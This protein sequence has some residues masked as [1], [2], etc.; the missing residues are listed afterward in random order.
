MGGLWTAFIGWFLNGAAESTRQEELQRELLHGVPVSTLMDPTPVVAT[1]GL[2]VQDFVFEDVLQRGHRALL[3]ADSGHL[4]GIVTLGDAKKLAQEDWPTTPVSKIMTGV[5][6]KT[7]TPESD[8]REAIGLMAESGLHQLPV[9]RNGQVV[10]LLSRTDI[11]RY[12]QLR[13]E[14]H[15]RTGRMTGAPARP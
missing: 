13:Q 12:L 3:V 11:V 4:F 8:L 2:S 14:L 1:P 15:L 7:V 10:G 5:P 9:T 6:L